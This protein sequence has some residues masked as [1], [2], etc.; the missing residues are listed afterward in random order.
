MINQYVGHTQSKLGNMNILSYFGFAAGDAWTYLGIVVAFFF[1]W[2]LLTWVA[3]A[4][5]RNYK[6]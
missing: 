1:G 2:S 6:R 4:Y 5:A 3:L